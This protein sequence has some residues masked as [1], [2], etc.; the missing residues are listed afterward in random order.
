M[1]T[2]DDAT[3]TLQELSRKLENG[4]RD[5]DKLE[6]SRAVLLE[7]LANK[8]ELTSVSEANKVLAELDKSIDDLEKQIILQVEELENDYLSK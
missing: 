8:Y 5:K 6:A 7:Q 2:I 1:K 4:L 3:D